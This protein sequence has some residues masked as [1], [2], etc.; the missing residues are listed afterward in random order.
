MSGSEEEV[1]TLNELANE[2][3]RKKIESLKCTKNCADHGDAISMSI[4][5]EKLYCALCETDD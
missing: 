5:G 4:K 3:I 1:F 2:N